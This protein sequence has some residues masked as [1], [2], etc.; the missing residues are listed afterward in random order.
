[1]AESGAFDRP[2]LYAKLPEIVS[3]AVPGRTRPDERI[4]V[5]T[6]G[7]VTQDVAISHCLYTEAVKHGM[8][9]RLP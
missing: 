7:L 1:M 6:E 8:G 9:T 4:L 5:R 2:K 3:G